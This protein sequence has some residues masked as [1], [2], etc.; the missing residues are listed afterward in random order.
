MFESM[1]REWP[2]IATSE[3]DTIPESDEKGRTEMSIKGRRNST[4][5]TRDMRDQTIV[6]E[7]D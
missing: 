4:Q 2:P 6:A 7:I 1:E 3:F 5:E